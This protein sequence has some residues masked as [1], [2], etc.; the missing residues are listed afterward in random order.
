MRGL[1]RFRR[2]ATGSIPHPR[3]STETQLHRTFLGNAADEAAAA[4]RLTAGALVGYGFGNIYALA[5]RPDIE[6]VRFANVLKGRPADQVGSVVTT[7]TRVPLVYDWSRIPPELSPRAVFG[8]MDALFS[9]GP[10][11]FRG[12]AADTVPEHLS[13]HDSASS[14]RTT[15]VIAPGY[16]CPSHT[17]VASCL[18]RTGGDVL[19]ITSANRSHH[20]TGAAEEPAHYRA[21]DLASEFSGEQGFLLLRHRDEA[22]VQ[23][24]YPLHAPMSTT[25]IGFHRTAG[26]DPEGRVRLLVERH[27]SLP[28]ED[29]RRLVRP[30]GIDLVLGPTAEKRLPQRRY[31]AVAG[32][33]RRSTR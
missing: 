22:R 13:Q 2:G 30:L 32:E 12:P 18:Q 15:Q 6:S 3:S 26:S 7:P 5:T 23:E 17:F 16:L 20:L 14:V 11:G 28:F 9:V 33:S 8:L 24:R 25:L 19:Y 27:G 21:D 4:E 31:D 10:F 29:A 1:R